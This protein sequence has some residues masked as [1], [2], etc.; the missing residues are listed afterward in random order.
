MPFIIAIDGYAG[1]GKSSTAKA[2]AHTLD[3]L[4]I[5]TGAMYRSI[6]WY[7][8]EH[9]VD[10]SHES[11]SV[12]AALQEITLTFERSEGQ[13]VPLICLNGEPVEDYIRQPEVSKRVS[14]VAKLA[15]VREAM[16]AQQRRLVNEE[17]VVMDGR[18]I[19]TVVFPHAQLKVFM[20][21]AMEIRAQR[22]L[23]ELVQK[24]IDS[25]LAD[26]IENLRARDHIDTTRDV[27]PLRQAED[28]VVID[29]THLNFQEQVRKVVT[30]ATNRINS[31]RS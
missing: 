22:R 25:N 19:G 20:T 29:T 16:V 10:Y 7:F 9:G 28:A 30:L 5:D 24:G 13:S 11:P 3:F 12:H 21:A 2:V 4:Y 8:G 17:N 14:P 18:D 23:E 1:T 26:T 6:A 31:M 27:A 15:V